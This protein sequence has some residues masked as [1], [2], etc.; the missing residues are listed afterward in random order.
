MTRRFE[1]PAPIRCPKCGIWSTC[2]DRCWHC[3]RP[4]S[5]DASNF[6]PGS[7]RSNSLSRGGIQIPP[8]R[9]YETPETRKIGLKSNSGTGLPEQRPR[10]AIKTRKRRNG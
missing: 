10:N 6:T 2:P 1:P 7:P 8:E 9:S 5:Q 3:G 4:R